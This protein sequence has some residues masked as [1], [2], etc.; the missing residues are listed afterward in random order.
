MWILK[1]VALLIIMIKDNS[2]ELV[3]LKAYDTT[4]KRWRHLNFLNMNAI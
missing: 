4:T 1:E 2:V 3:D